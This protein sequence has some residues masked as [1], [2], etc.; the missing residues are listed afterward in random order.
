ML[1]GVISNFGTTSQWIVQFTG[2]FCDTVS[3]CE[4]HLLM[5]TSSGQFIVAKA[6]LAISMTS[7]SWNAY[8][9]ALAAVYRRTMC[10]TVTE[11]SV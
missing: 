11:Q 10:S 2:Q 5:C 6:Y 8:L 7:L 9:L 3:C 4:Q 1:D